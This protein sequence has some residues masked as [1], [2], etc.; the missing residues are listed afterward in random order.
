MSAP[1]PALSSNGS[2]IPARAHRPRGV[3]SA[4]EA[5]SRGGGVLLTVAGSAEA[6]SAPLRSRT[7]RV[8]ALL[9]QAIHGVPVSGPPPGSAGAERAYRRSASLSADVGET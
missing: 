9:Q 8:A 3:S 6:L 5:A 1:E 2:A 4:R 7:R